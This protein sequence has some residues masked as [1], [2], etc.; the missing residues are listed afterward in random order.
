M[1]SEEDR[2]RAEINMFAAMALGQDAAVFSRSDSTSS[3]PKEEE[4]NDDHLLATPKKAGSGS[5]QA[6]MSAAAKGHVSSMDSGTFQFSS[7]SAQPQPA[8][9]SNL[10]AAAAALEG[11]DLN[12]SANTASNPLSALPTSTADDTSK[13]PSRITEDLPMF[14]EQVIMER[15]L[16]LGPLYRLGC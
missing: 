13:N 3:L 12:N 16:F 4:K 8:E 15:P 5:Q 14:A 6:F 7:S 2:Q 11:P 1:S 9:S 10:N